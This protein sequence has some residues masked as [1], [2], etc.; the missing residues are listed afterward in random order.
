MGFRMT[1]EESTRGLTE[2]SRSR[3]ARPAGGIEGF[4]RSAWERGWLP[5][6]LLV[7]GTLIAYQPVWQ[8]G[9]L[10][11]DD[12]FLVNNPLIRASDG[13]YRFWCTTEAPDY[14]PMT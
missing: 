6:L 12:I 7:A 5:V 14:F 3:P 8:A 13:L 1:R 9:F 4:V 10:W 2:T 11:D